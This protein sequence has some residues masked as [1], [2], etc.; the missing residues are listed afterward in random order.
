[1]QAALGGILETFNIDVYRVSE[2]LMLDSTSVVTFRA[3]YNSPV[4]ASIFDCHV[5]QCPWSCWRHDHS[6]HES[7]ACTVRLNPSQQPFVCSRLDS[8]VHVDGDLL[9]PFLLGVCH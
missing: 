1:M 5:I 7:R 4:L 2:M 3:R 9:K 6:E 8:S